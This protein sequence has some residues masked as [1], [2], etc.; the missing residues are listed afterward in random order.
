MMNSELLL[1]ARAERLLASLRRY[2]DQDYLA[3]HIDEA[4]E[5]AAARFRYHATDVVSHSRFHE[6]VAR[7]V[8][9]IYG[10]GLPSRVRLTLAQAH[11]ESLALIDQLYE[12]THARGHDAAVLDARRG[13]PQGLEM[14]L[15]R[16]T[17]ALKLRARRM[18]LRHLFASL[19][20]P[21][22]WELRCHIATR[23]MD[24]ARVW[25]PEYMAGCNGE[26]FADEIPALL[27]HC[28]SL[29]IQFGYISPVGQLHIA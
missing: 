24:Q 7:F 2:V 3:R 15:V 18:H 25:L 23:L 26:Q 21:A 28:L 16:L 12:G 22:D 29:E 19:L 20:D 10:K 1:Q 27:I 6:V 17:E 11:D 8:A 14:V 5:R 13:D 9:H 4:I